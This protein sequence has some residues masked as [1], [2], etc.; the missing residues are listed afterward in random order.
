MIPTVNFCFFERKDELTGRGRGRGAVG[1]ARH[2]PA[3]AR[4]K[5]AG[6]Q[7]FPLSRPLLTV[8]SRRHTHESTHEIPLTKVSRPQGRDESF[9]LFSPVV[10]TSL[11]SDH[12]RE[13]HL[14]VH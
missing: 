11:P 12:P 7:C 3:P 5:G 2:S 6:G 13:R 8:E 14:F 9:R 1:S 4:L 10:Q